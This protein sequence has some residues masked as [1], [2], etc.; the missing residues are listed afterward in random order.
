MAKTYNDIYMDARKRFKQAGISEYSQEARILLAH[1]AEKKPEE[2]YRDIRL[3]T[4][5]QYEQQAAEMIERRIRGE[6][7]AYLTGSWEFYGL[8]LVITKDV[9][10]P[11]TDTEIVAKTA[12]ELIRGRIA[13]VLD[14]CCGSG[15][16]GLAVAAYVPNTKIVLADKSNAALKVARRNAALNRLSSRTSCINADALNPP[17]VFLGAFEL[18]VS[19]P[20]YIKT[21]DMAGLDVSVRDFEPSCALDG[22]EDGLMFYESICGKWTGLLI[23]GGFLVFECGIGQSEDVRMIGEKYGL[24]FV[25]SV[26]D[27]LGIDR[28]VVFQKIKVRN[29][30][31]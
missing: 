20:P 3:Y 24:G 10:I 16:I 9:L 7:L 14:L 6:P 23:D 25:K 2:F 12:I 26:K 4:S 11:R 8:P 22:G 17:E 27:T 31:E 18:I 13:R 21:G 5:G 1:I 28:A 30:E 29:Q 19:N 15:C